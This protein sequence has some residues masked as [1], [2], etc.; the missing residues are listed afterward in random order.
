MV[1]AFAACVSAVVYFE[2]HACCDAG[3]DLRFGDGL[4]RLGTYRLGIAGEGFRGGCV[5]RLSRG[6]DGFLEIEPTCT[7]DALGFG[8]NE[9]ALT[10]ARVPGTFSRLHVE[11]TRGD[12]AL[13]D[14]DVV[15][16][17]WRSPSGCVSRRA[18]VPI[19]QTYDPNE[20]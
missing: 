5:L 10:S 12:E 2:T 6:E 4:Y 15:P 1:A 8:W 18:T 3:F 13:F 11:L 14:G 17:I 19:T 20:R 9:K 7:G 16:E